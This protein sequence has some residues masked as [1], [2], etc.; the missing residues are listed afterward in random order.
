MT[1]LDPDR[2]HGW[3]RAAAALT[4][5]MAL[6]P[7]GPA[8]ASTINCGDTLGAGSWLLEADLTCPSNSGAGVAITLAS[9]AALD[10][11]GHTVA[12]SIGGSGTD[13]QITGT[14]ASLQNGT[15]R[16]ADVAIA[17]SGGGGHRLSNLTLGDLVNTGVVFT[18][19]DGNV[20][21]DSQL[22]GAA[23]HGVFLSQSNKNRLERLVVDDTSG[24]G[25]AA[26][27]FLT[28]SDDNAITR[29]EVLRSQCTGIFVRDSSKNRICFN[30]VQDSFSFLN[31]PSVDILLRDA[32][33]QNLVCQNQVSA[34]KAPAVTFDGINVGCKDGCHCGLGGP[35]FSTPSTGADKNVVVGNTADGESRYGIAQATGNVD[36]HYPADEATGNGVADFAIDP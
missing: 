2:R 13:I 24:I 27:I 10:L 9:G 26:G 15:V 5:A 22:S 35:G 28:S 19:S 34:T 4:V 17:V 23:V 12:M 18:S 25:P 20:L 32:S 30:T 7:A 36:N 16:S 29:C 31:G 8:G 1:M 21:S 14:G 33:T 11:G 3:R 6:A